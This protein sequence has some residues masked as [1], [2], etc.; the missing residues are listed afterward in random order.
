VYQ[1]VTAGA[2]LL[3]NLP[4]LSTSSCGALL[5][6]LLQYAQ[7]A[8]QLQV[9]GLCM[10]H[11]VICISINIFGKLP[12]LSTSSCGALLETLLQYAQNATQLQVWIDARLLYA[13]PSHTVASV[14]CPGHHLS[15]HY[16][17]IKL[18]L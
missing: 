1:V 8:T 17:T 4:C 5:E 13:I 11:Q 18:I 7:N 12:R 14:C 15:Q 10:Q 16:H 2:L 3:G 9:S 6:N